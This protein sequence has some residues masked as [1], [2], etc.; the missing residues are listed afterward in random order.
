[1]TLKQKTTQNNVECRSK[2]KI[3]QNTQE[4]IE[5]LTRKK[6]A[7]A[8]HRNIQI[9]N[10]IIEETDFSSYCF[11]TQEDIL[12]RSERGDKHNIIKTNK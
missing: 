11:Q 4:E 7:R 12:S 2:H 3:P 1:M 8:K 9:M 6:G 10:L 5:K